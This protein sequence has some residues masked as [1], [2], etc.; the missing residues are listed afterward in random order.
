MISIQFDYSVLTHEGSVNDS[1][2]EIE[3]ILSIFPISIFKIC[4]IVARTI[5]LF[6]SSNN[7]TII[8]DQLKPIRIGLT[9]MHR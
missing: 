3:S 1:K 7:I 2:R 6:N 9:S 8:I 4:C 5:N